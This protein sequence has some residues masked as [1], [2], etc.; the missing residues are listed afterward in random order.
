M[1]EFVLSIIAGLVL[2]LFAVNNL[3]ESIQS[4]IG[5]SANKWIQ[6]FTANTFSSLLVGVVVTTLLDSSSAVI[7]ITIVLV[8]SQILTF[9]QAM[10]IVL[11][12]H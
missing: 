5:D 6:K 8:N 7:I 1:T 12:A 11:G 3:S 10:G 2:Y 4:I 9:K